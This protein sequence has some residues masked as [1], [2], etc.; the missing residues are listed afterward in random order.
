MSTLQE[1]PTVNRKYK[2]TLRAS[3]DR[4]SQYAIAELALYRNRVSEV[5]Q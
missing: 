1:K 5:C 3:V 4:Q 2:D